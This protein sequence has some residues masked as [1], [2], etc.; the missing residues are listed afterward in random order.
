[1]ASEHLRLCCFV[2]MDVRAELRMAFCQG[3]QSCFLGSL[4]A[5]PLILPALGC[6]QQ[7]RRLTSKQV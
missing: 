1:M 7:G 2:E 3:A 4:S 6:P 5:S